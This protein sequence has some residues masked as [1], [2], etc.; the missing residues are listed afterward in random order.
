MTEFF[1]TN[2]YSSCLNKDHASHDSHKEQRLFS[3][4]ALTDCTSVWRWRVFAATYE[5]NLEINFRLSVRVNAAKI[6][7]YTK[8]T[9][10]TR[11]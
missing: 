5:M 11:I 6:V 10:N 7:R 4:V 2:N 8:Q 3:C 9:A 1:S